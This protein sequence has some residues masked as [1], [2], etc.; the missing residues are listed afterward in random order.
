MIV[1]TYIFPTWMGYTLTSSV[2]KNGLSSIVSKMN[3]DGAIIF[4]D[5]DGAARGKDT[6]GAYDKESKSLWVQINHEG[7]NLEKDADRKTLFHEFGRAQDELLFKNQSKKENFQKIY[8]VE[9]NNITIDDS[10]KKNAEEFFAGVFSN[11]FSPDSK[12][13]E[14]IQTEAPKTSEFIR[15]LYQHATDFNGVKNYLIQYKIL[16]LN[17]ITKAEASKLG[18]KPGVDLNKVAPGKS[19][20]GDVFKNLEGKLPK[21]DG[22]TWYEVDIDFKDGK[23]RAKRILFANDRGNEVTLIYKTEDHYKTFQKLYEKE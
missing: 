13:R 8:E 23:R 19:I 15:N 7:H 1:D 22:R 3:K 2:P 16:P 21:K 6:K 20:G 12:K 17:F 5:Q 18:W 4:T 10:I 11:L 9:K 14:Q